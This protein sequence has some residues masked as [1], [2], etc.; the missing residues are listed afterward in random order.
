MAVEEAIKSDL[1]F[2]LFRTTLLVAFANAQ[3]RYPG[4]DAIAMQREAESHND[5]QL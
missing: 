5:I 1:M 3:D 4:V 2:Q